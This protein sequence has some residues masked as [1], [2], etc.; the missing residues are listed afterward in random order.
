MA[1]KYELTK[2][3]ETGNMMI[4][5]EHRELFGAVN[6]L[7][8]AC[9]KGQGQ[10]EVRNALDFLLRYVDRHFAHEEQLQTQNKY[11]EYNTHKRFHENYKTKLRE[12]AAK[13][14]PNGPTAANLASLNSHVALLISHI[15]TADKKLG[16]FLSR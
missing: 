8:D 7:L 9:E 4:D 13:V 1:M 2:E 11:P 14:G 3:L 16:A 12:I 15:R 6:K 5:R 10:A